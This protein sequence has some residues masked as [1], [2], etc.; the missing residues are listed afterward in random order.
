MRHPWNRT[1]FARREVQVNLRL[2]T[3]ALQSVFPTASHVILL[4]TL[5]IVEHGADMP[6]HNLKGE[7]PAGTRRITLTDDTQL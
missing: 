7:Q 4:I 2:V 3:R 6:Y 5:S 1:P